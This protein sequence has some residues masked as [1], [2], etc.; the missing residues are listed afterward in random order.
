MKTTRHSALLALA[1]VLGSSAFAQDTATPGLLGKRH[2]ETQFSYIDYRGT[3][4]YA[5]AAAFN[6]P[7]NASFD[8]GA[9][10]THTQQE[11]D[12]SQNY[13][14][15][16]AYLTAHRDFDGTR[17]FARATLNYEWWAVKNLWWYQTD[18]GFE[19]ALGDRVVV[20]A[21]ASWLDFLTDTFLESRFSGTAKLTWWAT[22]DIGVSGAF[23]LIEGGVRAY[24]LGVAFV[25]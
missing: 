13:Q 24:R 10:F 18:L 17:V 11:G 19:R 3:S 5:L 7:L 14:V 4:D 15:L 22:P 20:T 2:V 21:Y 8:A 6:Q 23:S 12:A 9:A 1:L 16:G 25:F